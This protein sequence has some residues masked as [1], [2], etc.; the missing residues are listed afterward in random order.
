[1]VIFLQGGILIKALFSRPYFS[2]YLAHVS[3][4]FTLATPHRSPAMPFDRRILDFY[5]RLHRSFAQHRP[6]ALGHINFVSIGGSANDKLI[7]A[8]LVSLASD[9]PLDLSILTTAIDDVS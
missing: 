4:V 9:N 3:V 8:D 7:R 2:P 5:D 1:M 6:T